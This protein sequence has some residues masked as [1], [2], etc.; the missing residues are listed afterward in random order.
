MQGGSAKPSKANRSVAQIRAVVLHTQTGTNS[1]WMLS[2]GECQNSFHLN[3]GSRTNLWGSILL[4]SLSIHLFCCRQLLEV[5]LH[6]LQKAWFAS[7]APTELGPGLCSC[8][9]KILLCALLVIKLPLKQAC[10][11]RHAVGDWLAFRKGLDIPGIAEITQGAERTKVWRP[12]TTG[13]GSAQPAR[14]A[15][16][17]LCPSSFLMFPREIICWECSEENC[18]EHPDALEGEQLGGLCRH[19]LSSLVQ[20][21]TVP[22]SLTTL[23]D[24][25][26]H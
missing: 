14:S 24:G 11:M 1:L 5:N 3:R 19:L 9:L 8:V 15:N 23:Q 10:A 21:E 6:R 2:S 17:S 20:E 7:Q 26:V 12:H 22:I 4:P 16:P 18:E 13:P 25:F